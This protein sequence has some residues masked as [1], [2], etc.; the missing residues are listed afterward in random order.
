[1]ANEYF[2]VNVGINIVEMYKQNDE[3]SNSNYEIILPTPYHPNDK[4]CNGFLYEW[5]AGLY[6]QNVKRH[7]DIFAHSIIF[8]QLEDKT[9]FLL[10]LR[11]EGELNSN[12]FF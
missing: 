9:D 5:C 4:M 3:R 10:Q 6:N 8:F 2:A 1:M 7:F 11:H 12:E